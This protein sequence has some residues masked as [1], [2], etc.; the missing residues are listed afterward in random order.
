MNSNKLCVEFFEQYSIDLFKKL[1]KIDVYVVQS[2]L[3]EV[4][5]LVIH[6]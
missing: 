6:F 3:R 5:D 4:Y 1:P 2:W